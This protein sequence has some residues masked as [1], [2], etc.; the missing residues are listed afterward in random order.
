MSDIVFILGAGAS[1][2]ETINN[3]L[4]L[5]L[6]NQFFLGKYLKRYWSTNNIYRPLL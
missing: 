1:H 4:P 3:K 2:H 5:P 6:A